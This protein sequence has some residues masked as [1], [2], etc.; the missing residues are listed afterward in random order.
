MVERVEHLAREQGLEVER[1]ETIR[2]EGQDMDDK[3]AL[4]TV[5]PI[6]RAVSDPYTKD[7]EIIGFRYPAST[8]QYFAGRGGIYFATSVEDVIAQCADKNQAQI[9]FFAAI[10]PFSYQVR[11]WDRSMM[12]EQTTHDQYCTGILYAGR[13]RDEFIKTGT[14]GNHFQPE[15]LVR[16][17]MT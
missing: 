17:W 7:I 11:A 5:I 4:A 12:R 9:N 13:E 1:Y 6:Y 16:F 8:T 3:D 14:H 15:V 10:S 2:D